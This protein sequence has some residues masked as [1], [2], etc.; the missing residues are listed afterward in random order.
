MLTG[1]PMILNSQVMFCKAIVEAWLPG[2]E[3]AG[4]ADVLY[5]G[6]YNFTGSLTHTWPATSAQIPINAGPVYSDEQH[7]ATGTPMFAY[8]F[9]LK[10]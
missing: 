8:E 9:G 3:G 7:G 10:Y 5:G 4:V 6:T 2:S 1:R